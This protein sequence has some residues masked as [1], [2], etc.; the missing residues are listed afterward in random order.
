[1]RTFGDIKPRRKIEYAVTMAQK[2]SESL[3]SIAKR[4]IALVRLHH[5]VDRCLAHCECDAPRPMVGFSIQ[6][7]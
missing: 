6:T 2:A 4:P 7:V 3:M 1:M 5:K